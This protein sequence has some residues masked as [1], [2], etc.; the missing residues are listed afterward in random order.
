[1]YFRILGS[2]TPRTRQKSTGRISP[3]RHCLRGKVRKFAFSLALSKNLRCGGRLFLFWLHLSLALPAYPGVTIVI[4]VLKFRH[5]IKRRVTKTRRIF[6]LRFDYSVRL[7]GLA[8]GGCPSSLT[9]RVTVLP[10]RYTSKLTVSPICF[11][12]SKR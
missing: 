5:K 1:M 10:S 2:S 9:G 12:S 7:T 3:F 6:C 4:K 11:L 8:A